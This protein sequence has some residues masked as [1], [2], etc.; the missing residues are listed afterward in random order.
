MKGIEKITIQNFKAFRNEKTFNLKG[1]HLLVYGPNGSG[2][3]SLYFALYTILQCDT[4]AP[5]KIKNYFD[6]FKDENLLN[7]HEPWNKA[8][9]IKL[10]LT[11]NK[12]KIYTLNNKGLSP[13]DPRQRPV[14]SEMNLASEFISHR[15][16]INFYNFRNS[17]EI[18]LHQ[19]FERD[20][21]PF[22]QRE[23]G[24]KIL[25]DEIIKDLKARGENGLKGKKQFDTWKAEITALNAELEKLI[26]YIDRNATDFLHTH[27][28]FKN[29]KI[30]IKVKKGYDFR[31]IATT[32]NYE[33]LP[34][35]IK[36]S[37]QQLK[38]PARAKN[39]DR[40]QSFLN[41][42]KLTAIALSIRFTILEKRPKKP[43]IKIL[44]LDDLLIS[45]DMSNRVDVLKMIFK[46]Y[47]KDY[48]LFFFTHE[49]GFYNEIKRWTEGNDTAWNYVVFKE[50]VDNKIQSE[51]DKEDIDKAKQFMK[52]ND[53]DSCALTLRKAVEGSIKEYLVKMKHYEEGKFHPLSKQIGTAINILQRET[54]QAI[55][56]IIGSFELPHE[57][58]KKFPV[59]TNAD[60][61]AIAGITPQ[62]KSKLKKIRAAVS[63]VVIKH[64]KE[65]IKVVELIKK[66]DHFVERSLNL[67]AHTSVAPIYKAELEEALVTVEALKTKLKE[68][69]L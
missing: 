35:F 53:F 14:L 61:D 57:I 1:K 69:Q 16:L 24:S 9:Y 68:I 52:D 3:S 18:D 29:L 49:R 25:F 5:A 51:N 31:K 66:A 2:K 62:E 22:V 15:L 21:F 45:L 48:Q 8:S 26:N 28:Q 6:R 27:F 44:A 13:A 65:N 30:V 40:P 41:E 36:L 12:K 47:E 64:H 37:I 56:E 38:P 4:K 33:I 23:T 10:V 39:I 58:L 20:I 17:K 54:Q 50:P 42:A 46:L 63:K 7:V 67:G 11:D 60:I 55:Q 43:E 32:S 59:A 19:V 34:P